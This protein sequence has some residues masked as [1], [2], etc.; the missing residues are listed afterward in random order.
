MT[1]DKNIEG[2]YLDYEGP[3][4]I[5]IISTLATFLSAQ[6]IAPITVR[7]KLYRI[8]I[9]LAQNVALYSFERVML[10]NG[11]EVG[12]GNVYVADLPNE[13]KCFTINR[14]KKEHA[15]ILIKNCTEINTSPSIA[16]KAKKNSLRKLA[17]IQDTGA[18]IGL[19]MVRL[20]SGNLI[21]FEIIDKKGKEIYLKITVTIN[22]DENIGERI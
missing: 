5:Q 17:Y 19:I 13:F 22:K 15:P 14:I 18:H 11:S 2:L 4:N 8:F 12:R 1:I 7:K 21:G 10:I 3:F 6:T 20:Y 16:L 9:E